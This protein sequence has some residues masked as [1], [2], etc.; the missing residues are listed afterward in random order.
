[1]LEKLTKAVSDF[2]KTSR[3]CFLGASKMDRRGGRR[4]GA[5]RPTKAQAAE[6]AKLLAE[7]IKHGPKTLPRQYLQALLDSPGSTKTE[8]LRAAELLLKCPSSDAPAASIPPP[9]PPIILA[10]PR[11]CFLSEEQ[12]ANPDQLIPHGV[13]LAPYEGSPDWTKS[14]VVEPAPI[15]PV[16]D[17]LEV[18][19][20]VDDG[21]VVRLDPFRDRDD[22]GPG[23]A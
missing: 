8:R 3:F 4:S 1:L 13:P 15:E 14:P 17:R 16:V 19:E 9:M 7:T 11:G 21:K 23:A 18:T 20:T 12:S 10:I 6:R 5:G 22:Q 2:L